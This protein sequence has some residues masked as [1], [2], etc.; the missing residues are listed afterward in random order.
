MLGALVCAVATVAAVPA[1]ASATPPPSGAKSPTVRATGDLSSMT[2][3]TGSVPAVTTNSVTSPAISAECGGAL[4]FGQIAACASTTGDRRDTYTITTTLNN[5]KLFT[6]LT[7]NSGASVSAEVTAP[8]G[9]HVC[10]FHGRAGNCQLG[11]AQVYTIAVELRTFGAG[12]GN[13]T[14]SV[15]SMRT[16][17]TCTTLPNSYF[18]F[19]SA[20]VQGSLPAGSAGDCYRFNQP[21]GSV[22]YVW[23]VI[24][25]GS[26]QGEILDGQFQPVCHIQ[27]ARN[28]TLGSAGPYRLH[29][30]EFYGNAT[31]YTMRMS[32]ISNA[33]GCAAL[34]LAPF[35]DPGA[36]AGSGSL[37]G[38]DTIACHK[39]AMPTAGTIGIRIYHA[40]Q[41]Y[42]HV[43]N[44]AGQVLC[45]KANAESCHLPA[46]G[47]YT[48]IALNQAWEP[49]T[50]QI[51]APAL[52][53]NGGCATGTGLSWALD[54]ILVRQTSAVQTNCQPFNGNAGDRVLVYKA[55]TTYNSVTAW[56]VDSTGEPICTTQ[57]GG[58]PCVLPATGRYRVIS[59]LNTWDSQTPEATYKMQVRR[60]SQPTGCPV[61]SPGAY[62]EAPTGAAGPIRCRILNIATPGPYIARAYNSENRITYAAVYDSAGNRICDDSGYCAIAA[63]GRYTMV[64][65]ARASDSVI[66]N[67]FSY[68]TALL[69]YQPS[70]CAAVSDTGYQEAPH[71]GE[72]TT[73]GQYNCLQ[74]P[75][76]AGAR[77]IMLVP[78]PQGTVYPTAYVLDATGAYICDSSWGLR[79]SSCALTGTAPYY[80]VLRQRDGQVPG[81]FAIAF[82]RV[83]NSPPCP[84]LPRDEN[85][86]TVTTGPDRFAAC[87]SI[88]ADQHAAR[89]SF[90][91]RRLSGT[92]DATLWVFNGEGLRYC[93]TIS[94]Y[95]ERTITCSLP[96]GPLTVILETDAVD[97]SYQITHRDGT[98][99]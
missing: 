35:G 67:D 65:D 4:A 79:E 87:F 72:F 45:H 21:V 84:V 2:T 75:S 12:S 43:Y 57:S 48:V 71:R 60:L 82:A 88:P 32:R 74:L 76:P 46:A 16:P 77:V 69:P 91:W 70:G 36:A 41:I 93:G 37:G 5:D 25:N 68:V 55:P 3:A 6:M 97:A 63:A 15:Q 9:A 1:A 54:A 90:S 64:L 22:V 13:Y 86:L 20:G 11:A 39:I 23:P 94:A 44:N 99:P 19:A 49:I 89:E 18:S 95:P 58:D 24:D 17:S 66:D 10:Y 42:W 7:A 81:A 73:P 33:A 26:V 40:Q 98:T 30:F 53:R 62:N 38:Q 29:L 85:G 51:A 34:R 31:P 52:F 47:N 80:V 56:L 50:Y 8:D 27:Y 83:D 78:D 96:E 59:H 61:I 28:C 92:G 14:L